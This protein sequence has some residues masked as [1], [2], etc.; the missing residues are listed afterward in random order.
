MKFNIYMIFAALWVC[1]IGYSET[2]PDIRILQALYGAGTTQIDVTA[3]VQSLVQSGTTGARVGN[4]L[5]DK[6]PVVGKT[7]TLHLL[8][9]SNGVQYQTDIREGEQLSFSNDQRN[10]AP[11]AP[12]TLIPAA[13]SARRRAFAAGS[14]STRRAPSFT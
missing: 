9:S 5:F 7:K 13:H 2:A 14:T 8:F 1:Q 12:A 3:K 4:H 11:Q 6:D 10:V